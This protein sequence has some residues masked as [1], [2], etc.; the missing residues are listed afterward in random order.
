MKPRSLRLRSFPWYALLLGIY[1][2]VA[3]YATNVAEV[4]SA[5]LWRPLLASLGTAGALLVLLRLIFKD[6]YRAA[7]LTT[8]L[9]LA[10]FSYGHLYPSL[11]TISWL[12]PLVRHRILLPVWML[13]TALVLWLAGRRK[14]QP[15]RWTPAL[16]IF[17][18]IAL[19]FPLYNLGVHFSRSRQAE[20]AYEP[21]VLSGLSLPAG[22]TPPD[23]YYIIL[24]AYGNTR[25]LQDLM[26]YD[27]TVFLDELRDQGFYVADC[28]QSNYAFTALSLTSSLNMNYLDAI[29]PAFTA[30]NDDE[31]I[32]LYLKGSTTRLTLEQ[33]GY[34]V[35]AFETG[36]EWSNWQ[37]ADLFLSQDRWK[38]LNE[39]EALLVETSV[40]K[41]LHDLN[42]QKTPDAGTSAHRER[43]LFTLENLRQMPEVPGPKF[44]FAHVIIPHDPLDIG[45]N[46]EYI[47]GYD[48]STRETY[49]AGYVRQAK[50][51]SQVIPQITAAILENSATPPVI[52]IQGD[53]GPW[54]YGVY[55]DRLGIL[56]AIYLPG[57]M[58][59]FDPA[60]TPVNT[61]RRIFNLYFGADLEM[62]DERSYFSTPDDPFNLTEVLNPCSGK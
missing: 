9:M 13:L 60:M 51:I 15:V 39:F 12:V 54:N 56:N 46:G 52:I 27:N 25:V 28:S 20:S 41:S 35:I 1:P 31:R 32:P 36:Y 7:V 33:F 61:F 23:I 18:V 6:W 55:A 40:L 11:K 37:D 10:F 3:L 34:K 30:G 43:V 8:I 17:A 5:T 14:A 59:G 58:D 19:A 2:V 16:N 29:D 49:Y 50:Y 62:L 47:E 48:S 22:Q 4:R 21:V 45:E 26:A 44:V 42:L 53:H 38:G 57:G 24:D